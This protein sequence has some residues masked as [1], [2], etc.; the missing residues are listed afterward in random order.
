MTYEERI[1]AIALAWCGE[2]TWAHMNN[3]QRLAT[4]G[5]ART[6]DAACLAAIERPNGAMLVAATKAKPTTIS[7]AG[8]DIFDF[9]DAQWR[10]MHAEIPRGSK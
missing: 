4:L 9:I 2:E 7:Q 3:L 10:A 1:E 6:A 8:S 5:R